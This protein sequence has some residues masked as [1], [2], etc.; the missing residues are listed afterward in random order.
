MVRLL[1]STESQGLMPKSVGVIAANPNT[2]SPYLNSPIEVMP[3]AAQ[4]VVRQWH[5]WERLKLRRHNA[6]SFREPSVTACVEAV[7]P[8]GRNITA[9]GLAP[10]RGA[11]CNE[12]RSPEGQKHVTYGGPPSHGDGS[13]RAG[14]GP[15]G[16]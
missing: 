13:S 2:S 16:A 1:F 5:L 12:N 14:L 10:G 7:A 6:V 9:R 8:K 3:G 11:R 4:E 15:S